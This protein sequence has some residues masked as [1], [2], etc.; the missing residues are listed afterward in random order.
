MCFNPSA[1][2]LKFFMADKKL[3]RTF[4]YLPYMTELMKMEDGG[5]KINL[6]RTSFYF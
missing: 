4:P 3:K 1:I 2:Q 5:K 6:I